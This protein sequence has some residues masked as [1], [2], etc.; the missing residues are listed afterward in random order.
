MKSS[1]FIICAMFFASLAMGCG[2]EEP[3]PSA[4]DI[5]PQDSEGIFLDV[6][7]ADEDLVVRIKNGSKE[8]VSLVDEPLIGFGLNGPRVGLVLQKNEK[9]VI[10]CAHLDPP[11]QEDPPTHLIP[12]ESEV[13]TVNLRLLRKMYCLEAGT[14]TVRAIYPAD[15]R[16]PD[17]SSVVSVVF[18]NDVKAPSL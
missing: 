3:G 14:Y 10:P 2:S 9:D 11:L 8:V 16:S 18:E 6:S 13:R 4:L 7:V 12:G 15:S 1:L 17:S 5:A